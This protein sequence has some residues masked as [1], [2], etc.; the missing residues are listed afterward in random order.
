MSTYFYL[1]CHKCGEKQ[2]AISSSGNLGGCWMANA[3]K[4]M[5][6]FIYKHRHCYEIG[7]ISEHYEFVYYK[8]FED[9]KEENDDT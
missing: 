1:A 7:I 4:A 8:D 2:A 3:I 9:T 6:N 5:P